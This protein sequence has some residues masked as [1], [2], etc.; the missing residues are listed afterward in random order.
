MQVFHQTLVFFCK[1]KLFSISCFLILF[2]KRV[3]IQFDFITRVFI[4]PPHEDAEVVSVRKICL[5]KPFSEAD[6]GLQQHP[7]WS[8]L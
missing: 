4:P 2:L 8:A 6:L 5:I 7:R 1:V 3:F